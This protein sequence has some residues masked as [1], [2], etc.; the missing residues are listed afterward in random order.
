MLSSSWLESEFVNSSV[1]ALESIFRAVVHST[2]LNH[3][4]KAIFSPYLATSRSGFIAEK[5]RT[6]STVLETVF[7]S[8][9]RSSELQTATEHK[10]NKERGRHPLPRLTPSRTR[11]GPYSK[12]TKTKL[13]HVK[14]QL[15]KR[16][17][18]VFLPYFQ[19]EQKRKD[20][21]HQL[22]D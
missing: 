1:I 18:R 13:E 9:S 7:C 11:T 5:I 16:K 3:V 19:R 21:V 17:S 6:Q 20:E 14:F 15:C 10:K 8:L 12:T 4:Y 2:S 22:C